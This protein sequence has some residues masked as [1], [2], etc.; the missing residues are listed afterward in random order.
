[1]AS[2]SIDEQGLSLG[3]VEQVLIAPTADAPIEQLQRAS[4]TT[5]GLVGDR[6]HLR[7][8]TYSGSSDQRGRAV[9][10]VEAEVLEAVGLT[11]TQARRNVVTRGVRLNEL[12][13]IQFRIGGVVCRGARLCEPCLR[14]EKATG[15]TVRELVHRA[16]STRMCSLAAS[17]A[18]GTLC[19]FTRCERRGLMRRRRVDRGVSPAVV[20]DVGNRG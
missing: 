16:G 20:I 2:E 19:S 15:V 7:I 12:V 18:L 1:M 17:C 10:L 13:G 9:T 3:R 14:L 8:G 4:V 11:G 6:Y 5:E